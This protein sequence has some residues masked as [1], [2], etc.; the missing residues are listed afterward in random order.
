MADIVKQMQ[1]L[2]QAATA[3]EKKPTLDEK[4]ATD[5][6]R[7]TAVKAV[8]NPG[9]WLDFQKLGNKLREQG[10][11]VQVGGYQSDLFAVLFGELVRQEWTYKK[12]VQLV[13]QIDL[14][15]ATLL[16]KALEKSGLE[17]TGVLSHLE[18]VWASQKNLMQLLLL[19]TELETTVP[20]QD[21][22][23][24]LADPLLVTKERVAIIVGAPTNSAHV[25]FSDAH[26]LLVNSQNLAEK[27]RAQ[28]EKLKKEKEATDAE[29][30]AKEEK[31]K[32]RQERK[33]LE[34]LQ[35]AMAARIAADQDAARTEDE[36]K[37]I[38]ARNME[39]MMAAMTSGDFS[40]LTGTKPA[41]RASK[42]ASASATSSK[43]SPPPSKKSKT[44][45]KEVTP[46]SSDSEDDDDDVS[47]VSD[48]EQ[49]EA[50]EE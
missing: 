35:K 6:E 19:A 10:V 4:L 17:V 27:Q 47:D 46:P 48:I 32:A 23:G 38:M 33:E 49:E 9:A 14:E 40:A 22:V 45:L 30:K 12:L 21:E 42:P 36:K 16:V 7:Y 34:A 13:L 11:V 50:D 26:R 28:I 29:K 15:R 37:A 25:A 1:A 41:R 24:G 8:M 18:K 5:G 20:S 39:M 3:T 31:K 43:K 2:L 44:P